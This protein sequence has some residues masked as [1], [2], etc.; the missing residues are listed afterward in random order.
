MADTILLAQVALEEFDA[1]LYLGGHGALCDLAQ[2]KVSR[3]I[4]AAALAAGKPLAF[5]GHGLAA[6]LHATDAQ[7]HRLLRGRRV[8]APRRSEEAATGLAETLPVVLE[9]ELLSLGARYSSGP[10]AASHVVRDGLLITGQN[11]GSAAEVARNLLDQ[12]KN[13]G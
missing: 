10:D 13:S 8:T 4:A 11:T 1:V 9:D 2:D 12:L 3:D 5:V 7:G 6:L